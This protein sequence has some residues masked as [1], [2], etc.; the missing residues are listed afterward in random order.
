MFCYFGNNK[1][2]WDKKMENELIRGTSNICRGCNSKDYCC[3]S[4]SLVGSDMGIVLKLDELGRETCNR[5]NSLLSNIITRE[6]ACAKAAEIMEKAESERLKCVE[7][8]AKKG[9]C[10]DEEKDFCNI[11]DHEDLMKMYCD[12]LN[13]FNDLKVKYDELLNKKGRMND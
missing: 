3:K 11:K 4:V 12:L 6:E 10:Y 9:I 13:N 2:V 1:C 5:F 7:E 8:E